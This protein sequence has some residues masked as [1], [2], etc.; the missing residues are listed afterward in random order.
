MKYWQQ[1]SARSHYQTAVF[2]KQTLQAGDV[3]E[4][5]TGIEEL[6]DALSR[7]DR[8]AL[9]SHL[10]RL[11]THAIKWQSQPEARSLSWS[12][13]IRN[14]RDDIADIQ[15]ETPSL[16]EAVIRQM[17]DKCFTAAKREAEGEMN[18][19]TSMTGLS[20]DEVFKDPYDL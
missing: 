14:A 3:R 9:R 4:A 13:S 2:I 7:S 16:T 5:T 15:E 1:L 10:V 20:W 18:Q 8:R 19:R 17:W 11:M 12:A 6:I